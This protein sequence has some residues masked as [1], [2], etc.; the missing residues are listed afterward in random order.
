MATDRV[1]V[2]A[3]LYAVAV[4]RDDGADLSAAL[5]RETDPALVRILE[6]AAPY[7]VPTDVFVVEG[8]TGQPVVDIEVFVVRADL[9]VEVVRVGAA[10]RVRL[11]GDDVIYAG[12]VWN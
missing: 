1:A 5:R 11:P 6:G 3:A 9:S 4:V 7:G 2:R 8:V 10:G 12:V